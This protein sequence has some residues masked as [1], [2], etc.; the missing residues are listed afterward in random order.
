MLSKRLIFLIILSALAIAAV[1]VLTWVE[2]S[3]NNTYYNADFTLNVTSDI[4]SDCVYQ[5]NTTGYASVDGNGTLIHTK[6]IAV[7]AWSEL[8]NQ[9][10]FVKCNDTA[11]PAN[12]TGETYYANV[13]KDTTAPT[14]SYPSVNTSDFYQG[15]SNFTDTSITL[16]SQPS[17]TG[18]SVDTATCEFYDNVTAS[19]G[20]A[21]WDGSTYCFKAFTPANGTGY[22]VQFRINDT[23]DNRGT[24]S[25]L[26]FA[27]DGDEPTTTANYTNNTAWR[28]ADTNFSFTC[29][30][31][32]GSGC[33]STDYAID[34]GSFTAASSYLRTTD[35]NFTVTYRSTDNVGN[36]ESNNT[37]YAGM[38]QTDPTTT[39][40]QTNDTTWFTAD[41]N[42]GFTCTDATSGCS[43]NPGYNISNGGW[44]TGNFTHSTEGNF[45]MYYN[46]TDTAGNIETSK[47]YAGGL[48]KTAPTTTANLTNASLSA[49]R[50]A[51]FAV[52]FTCTDAT[53][54]CDT[55][56]YSFN[57][58]AWTTGNYTVST[59]G[60][61]T[62]NYRS[63]DT[64][65]VTEDNNTLV[66]G[67]DKTDPTTTANYTNA[68]LSG[69]KNADF[70][71]GLT[72][73]DATSGCS[74]NPGYNFNAGGWATGN[75]TVSTET[76]FTFLFNSTDNAGLIETTQAIAG[77]LDKTNATANFTA[78]AVS[79]NWYNDNYFSY[80]LTGAVSDTLS[81][82]KWVNV[83]TDNGTS[84]NDASVTG[85]VWNY[86]W[87]NPCAAGSCIQH[88]L[89]RVTDNAN[90][91]NTTYIQGDTNMTFNVENTGPTITIG[92]PA[93]N[94][95]NT[96]DNTTYVSFNLTDTESGLNVTAASVNF[97]NGSTSFYYV[98]SSNL[99]CNPITNG[100]NCSTTVA[101]VSD[102][103]YSIVYYGIDNATNPTTT[104]Y[105]IKID[106][107]PVTLHSLTVTDPDTFICA[108]SGQNNLND[109]L[110]ISVN[111][112]DPISGISWIRA[113]ISAI[114]ASAPL[115]SLTYDGTFWNMSVVVN[116]TSTA[117]FT[118]VNVSFSASDNAGNIGAN[119][120]IT[121]T[122]VLL[123]M[124]TTP[125][126]NA[127][128]EQAGALATNFCNETNFS[129]I[130]FTQAVMLNGSSSCNQGFTLPW[131][132]TFQNIITLNFGVLNFTDPNTGAIL[133]GMG[134]AIQPYITPPQSFGDSYIAVNTTGFAA[135]NTSTNI[136]MY[137]LP[138]A[139]TPNITNV[140]GSGAITNVAFT[141]NAPYNMSGTII[142]N[143]DL[144]F[145]VS[146]FS[147]YNI[148][149]DV[150]PTITLN[151]PANGS[152]TSNNTVLINV[153]VNGTGTQLSNVTAAVN[154]TAV[155]AY[156]NTQI[157]N[158]C[159]NNTANWEVVTCTGVTVALG[160]GS[161][162]LTV[163]AFDFGGASPGNSYISN[164]T[165]TV[166]SSAPTV[167]LSA[168][169]NNSWDN[170]DTGA[171]GM[172]PTFNWT[173]VDVTDSILTCNVTA[174]GTQVGTNINVTNNTVGGVLTLDAAGLAEAATQWY[175]NCSDDSAL[176]GNSSVWTVNLDGTAPF[177][178]TTN[179]TNNSNYTGA[180]NWTPSFYV[181]PKDALSPNMSCAVSFNNAT[182]ASG[183][184]TIDNNTNGS[185]TLNILGDTT[186]TTRPRCT[187]VVGNTGQT[188]GVYTINV[189]ATPT[190][191]LGTPAA[192]AST[193]DTTPTFTYTVTENG[194]YTLCKLYIDSALAKTTN[195]TTNYS[196]SSGSHTPTTALSVDAHTWYVRCNDTQNNTNTSGTRTVTI[197]E[198][199]T[200][201][202]T[203]TD[204]VAG[205]Q[206][207][208][209][210]F[211]TETT[212]DESTVEDFSNLIETDENVR[213]GLEDAGIDLTDQAEL[214]AIAEL[215]AEVSQHLT[216]TT[217]VDHISSTASEVTLTVSYTGGRSLV[218]QVVV[219]EIPKS[220]ASS[221]SAIT[222]DAGGATVIV[223]QSDPVFTIIF[224]KVKQDTERVVRFITN[225]YINRNVVKNQLKTP[226]LLT[227]SVEEP[228]TPTPT[229]TPVPTP[230]PTPTP[231]PTVTPEVAAFDMNMIW[232]GIAVVILAVALIAYFLFFK[233]K[234]R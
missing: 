207:L 101:A 75:Y 124:T 225:E 33:A 23:I 108:Y 185:I 162:N 179:F 199:T 10:I 56:Q 12:G 129:N 77:G 138:F 150:N 184:T 135:L 47:L 116:D 143:G 70:T 103:Q 210:G 60:N 219:I 91:E 148:S 67:L 127:T 38:D 205:A 39:V 140:D 43:G 7:G 231:V 11:T 122:L 14:L 6:A 62:L 130:N 34:D 97:T 215:S 99:S 167:T 80:N 41:I 139:V 28:T 111:A 61:F 15:T 181:L 142:P 123:N 59:E 88:L 222:V 73:T 234:G 176:V 189:N 198:E 125:F 112:S 69:W 71:I 164:T 109:A 134:Q 194:L 113:N 152:S 26:E 66:G 21:S 54:G 58:G 92:S 168:P 202:T 192:G 120:Q 87:A 30:D 42:F 94:I 100:Y 4:N 183:N 84:W 95:T 37:V 121:T 55:T 154:G 63:N 86:T 13:S 221:S 24:S 16:I 223:T 186:Y 141:S 153:T 190:L 170:T 110:N 90:N 216:V 166:D 36:V 217:N 165:F 31:G 191:S 156:N 18:S 161:H 133:Q 98:N 144:S 68:T 197:T 174:G 96:T 17:A 9:Q 180:G 151:T 229:P 212:L 211:E 149:D 158:S 82:V 52:G 126:P 27:G 206:P 50:V 57:S 45:S 85:N 182:L 155:F 146:A 2:P 132:N 102:G 8:A 65:G 177:S 19:W 188:T 230:T 53:S 89:V 147:Q 220:F 226:K 106:N 131:G 5:V 83:S 227:L 163:Y 145:T 233:K 25:T 35:G 208:E 22:S 209:F 81:G 214:D 204:G 228:V 193:T 49:W 115:V 195:H 104:T 203:S 44:N 224:D 232:L 187:D 200:T 74:G 175:V 29:G 172:N 78:P 76:N 64:A 118:N 128:C 20:A 117:N 136:T 105:T 119:G 72:C 201:T 173:V 1:P 178:V 79:D 107:Q 160:D 159:S 114:N 218:G 46:S 171:A 137:G 213:A 32:I 3:A 40:N 157:S 51:D 93:V 169:T 48:D 196:S